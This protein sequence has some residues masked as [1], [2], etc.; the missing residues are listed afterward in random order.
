MLAMMWWGA[1]LPPRKPPCRGRDATAPRRAAAPQPSAALAARCSSPGGDPPPCF[2]GGRR[3]AAVPTTGRQL[4]HMPAAIGPWR[5]L[6]GDETG[7]WQTRAARAGRRSPSKPS[8]GSGSMA[9]R[10]RAW[11]LFRPSAT[12][13]KPHPAIIVR[14]RSAVGNH[15]APSPPQSWPDAID[16]QRRHGA[17][18]RE[19]TR[20]VLTWYRSGDC[21]TASRLRA[22]ICAARARLRG[23]AGARRVRRR[24]PAR[25]FPATTAIPV[26]D[27]LAPRHC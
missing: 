27:E 22:K 15:V 7:D 19:R 4:S 5:K 3:C 21:I 12:A 14:R 13:A 10:C 9:R 26:L 23:R 11:Q 16:G 25:G 1:R 17:Q 18:R 20:S 2:R 8:Y 6:E 24:S